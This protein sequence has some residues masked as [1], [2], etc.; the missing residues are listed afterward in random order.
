A[1]NQNANDE[2]ARVGAGTLN[3]PGADSSFVLGAATLQAGGQNG[4]TTEGSMGI[5]SGA[6]VDAGPDSMTLNADGGI[7]FHAAQENELITVTGTRLRTSGPVAKT[8]SGVLA[9]GSR[10]LADQTVVAEAGVLSL[11]GT[12]ENVDAGA[13]AL[14]LEAGSTLAGTGTVGSTTVADGG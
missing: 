7:T 14:R 4:V 3:L 9:V 11:S 10:W 2:E 1:A 8:G 6:I 12:L 13:D 5:Q